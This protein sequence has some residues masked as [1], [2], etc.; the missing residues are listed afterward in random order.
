MIQS[1]YMRL[2]TYQAKEAVDILLEKGELKIT[3]SDDMKTYHH[4]DD[5]FGVN[6]FKEAYR[7]IIDRMHTRVCKDDYEE[8]IIDPIW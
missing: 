1:I 7:Y 8:G 4:F 3:S 6:R 2:I 5:A